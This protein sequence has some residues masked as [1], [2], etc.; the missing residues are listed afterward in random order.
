[1]KRTSRMAL[2]MR[3]T[4]STT[5]PRDHEF[6][7]E[8][9]LPFNPG[10]RNLRADEFMEIDGPALVALMLRPDTLAHFSVSAMNLLKSAGER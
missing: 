7:R 5:A 3:D 10:H 9:S 2:V 8:V 1:M 6:S 4:G